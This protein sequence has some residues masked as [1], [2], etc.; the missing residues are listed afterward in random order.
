MA[1]E[2][3]DEPVPE[4][5]VQRQT[6]TNGQQHV[7][8]NPPPH[9]HRRDSIEAPVAESVASDTD[10][11]PLT[12]TATRTMIEDENRS[13]LFRI[14]S[15]L[16]HRRAS[17]AAHPSPSRQ[18]EGLN[19]NDPTVDPDNSDFDLEKWLRQFMN[20][21]TEGG[22]ESKSLGVSFRNL[23]VFGSG[24]ALQLQDTVGSLLAAPLRPGD[25]FSFNKKQRKQIIHGF[26]GYL[27][28]GELLIVLGRPG[29]G[30]STFL[31]TICGELEG[32]E[33]GE[34]S[35]IHY[36]GISQKQMMKEFKGELVY[37]QEVRCPES[38]FFF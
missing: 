14:A 1:P 5:L 6:F 4:G 27:S 9:Q 38:S 7:S 31:K 32:L 33:I 12:R 25:F 19:E 35:N 17:L 10:H 16:S 2:T 13:E 28:P 24:S 8:T 30:C 36:K 23:D 34:E 21:L 3:R 15:A 20:Q 29:S 18:S 26:D 37:N 11:E 22:V